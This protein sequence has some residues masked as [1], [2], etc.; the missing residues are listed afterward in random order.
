MQTRQLDLDDICRPLKETG[1]RKSKMFVACKK[2][3]SRG[4][5]RQVVGGVY[6]SQSQLHRPRHEA[7]FTHKCSG[8]GVT[9]LESQVVL[10][11]LNFPIP[12]T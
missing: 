1:E 4:Q 5:E 12:M 6:L 8:R 11:N 9:N 3:N 2:C 7:G 10:D